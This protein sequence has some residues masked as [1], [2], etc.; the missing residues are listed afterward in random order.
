MLY[1]EASPG[2][3]MPIDKPLITRKIALILR[4]SKI[5]SHLPGYP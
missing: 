3:A 1:K 4:I 2:S 5:S